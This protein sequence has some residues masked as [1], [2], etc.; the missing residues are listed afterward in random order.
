MTLQ[1]WSQFIHSFQLSWV[2]D[3]LRNFCSAQKRFFFLP[4]LRPTSCHFAPS[5]T[6]FLRNAIKSDEFFNCRLRLQIHNSTI[7]TQMQLRSLGRTRSVPILNTI[8]EMLKDSWSRRSRI[9]KRLSRRIW[10]ALRRLLT[11]PKVLRWAFLFLFWP[12][13]LK[14]IEN[15]P[16]INKLVKFLENPAFS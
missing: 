6:P 14:L 10:G 15:L 4:I 5:R 9:W 12:F 11:F 2:H 8:L 16:G 1:P 3:L 7:I 13:K